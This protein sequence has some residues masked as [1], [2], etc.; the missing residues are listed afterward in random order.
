MA[1]NLKVLAALEDSDELLLLS[2]CKEEKGNF[3]GIEVE[4]L[5]NEQC[6]SFF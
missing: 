6:R 5:T 3:P 1:E 2:L 4:K